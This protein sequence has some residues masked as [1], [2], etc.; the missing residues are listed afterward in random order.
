M[1][2]IARVNANSIWCVTKSPGASG[3]DSGTFISYQTPC[4]SDA[5]IQVPVSILKVSATSLSTEAP[6]WELPYWAERDLTL[7]TLA[8]QCAVSRSMLSLIERGE[9]SPTAVVLEKVARGLGVSLAALFDDP[10]APANP[11][12]RRE[13]R[14]PWRDPASGY[15]RRN[16]SPENYPSPIKIVEVILPA[17]ARIAYESGSRELPLAQQIWVQQG[18][19]DVTVGKM[20]YRLMQDDCLAMPLNVAISFQN[21]TQKRVRYI[22][23]VGEERARSGDKIRRAELRGGLIGA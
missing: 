1:H 6:Y 18:M 7:D 19:L 22:V 15:I 4:S 23:V 9:S 5:P 3:R 21:R 13:D 17:R 11:V 12:A 14:T 20:A 10:A 16:I 8:V 2:G